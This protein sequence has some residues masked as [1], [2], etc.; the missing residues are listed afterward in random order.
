M[1]CHHGGAGTTATGLRAARPTSIVFF[2]ADQPFWG[3]IVALKDVGAPPIP[4]GALS[5]ARLVEAWRYCLQDRVKENAKALAKLLNRYFFAIF[6]YLF[7][8]L[9]IY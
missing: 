2:F 6:F 3:S 1:V 5:S 9:L 8:D 7:I 4:F